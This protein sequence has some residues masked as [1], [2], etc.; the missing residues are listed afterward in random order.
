MDK[1]EK[2]LE[3]FLIVAKKLCECLEG[4][5]V[6]I[7]H[8]S[9]IHGLFSSIAIAPS[10]IFPSRWL[11]YVFGSADGEMPEFNTESNEQIEAMLGHVFELFN[12]TLESVHDG[13]MIPIH[14]VINKRGKE[15]PDCAPWS[16]GFIWGIL[17][18]EEGN[19]KF[20]EDRELADKLLPI[21]YAS[22]IKEM[23]SDLYTREALDLMKSQE[24]NL[25]AL[26]VDAFW[27][28]KE[29]LGKDMSDSIPF[30][31]FLGEQT[32]TLEH[33]E[34]IGRNDP[35]PCGSGK[36]YKKCCGK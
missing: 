21:V 2:R 8:A 4:M 12:N 3:D 5:D 13:T 7:M 11:P 29:Y 36:K 24:K 22:K 33:T 35:C 23:C 20:P 18:F 9:Y 30:P 1:Y 16:N 32:G 34:R 27:D 6:K 31:S 17:G 28:V 14:C 10:P 19:W 26:I 25:E 15:Y